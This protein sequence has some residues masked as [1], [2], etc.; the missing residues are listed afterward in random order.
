M[1]QLADRSFIKPLG[2]CE[3]VLIKVDELI[4]PADFY[5][6]DMEEKHTIT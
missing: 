3:N 5:I 6:L 4:F 1:I 2:L